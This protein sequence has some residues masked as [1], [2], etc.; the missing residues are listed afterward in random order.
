MRVIAAQRVNRSFVQ[1]DDLAFS[2]FLLGKHQ[3]V[4]KSS[5]LFVTDIAPAELQKVADAERGIRAED[6]QHIISELSTLAEILRHRVE[7]FFVPDRFCYC[8]N[9]FGSFLGLCA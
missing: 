2:G 1:R 4:E 3:V 8:H 7:F 6:N 9:G 5:V